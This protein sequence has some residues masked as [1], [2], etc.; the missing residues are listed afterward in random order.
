MQNIAVC[1]PTYKRPQLLSTTLKSIVDNDISGSSIRKVDIIVVDNDGER[2]AESTV[3]AFQVAVQKYFQVEYFSFAKKGLANVRN[4]L[5][6][7]AIS[8]N[9]A[10]IVF[11]DDDEY[12]SVHWLKELV[13]TANQQKADMVAGP[14]SS[15]FEKPVPVYLERWFKQPEPMGTKPVETIASNNLLIRT[16]FLLKSGIRFDQRFNTT[17]AE[18]TYFGIEAKK[19]GAKIQWSDK[20]L[21]YE[22]VFENRATLNWLVKRRYRGAITYTYIMM[23]EKQHAQLVKKAIVSLAYLF[24]GIPGLFLLPFKGKNKYWGILKVSEGWGGLAGL[25]S[26]KYHEYK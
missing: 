25:F 7:R 17:G 18:D 2:S 1:I 20:A 24:M 26:V 12:A 21:V 23:L 16:D 19:A 14:V 11:I 6:E 9:P 22:T 5:L 8:L 4:A 15:V 10:F 13:E 3:K